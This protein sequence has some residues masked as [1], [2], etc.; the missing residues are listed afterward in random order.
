MVSS[1]HYLFI[2]LSASLLFAACSKHEEE[3]APVVTV[4]VAPVLSSEIQRTIRVQGL[5]YPL[6]QAAIVP[7]ITAPIKKVSVQ[8][9]DKVKAGQLLLELE[10]GDL[11]GAAHEAEAAYAAAEATYETTARAAVPEEAQ[12]AELDVQSAKTAMDAAQA[13]YDNRQQLFREGAIAQKDVNDA[14]VNFTQAKGQYE[15]AQKRLSDLRSFGHDQA[16]KNAA[17]QRDQAKARMDAALAQLSYSRITSP[18]DGVVTERPFYAGETPQ[19]GSPVVTVMDISQVIARTHISPTEAS[20]LKVGNEANIIG[21]DNTPISA[22]V[23][24]VSPALDGTNSTIEVWAQAD[25]PGDHLKPGASVRV[26]LI[27]KTVPNAL[28]IPQSALL[29]SGSGATSVVIVDAENKPHK[30]SVTT[31]VR[32]AGSVQITDGLES[33][34]R[35]VTTGAFELAKL[36]P[37]VLAKT[38]VQIAPPKEEEEEEPDSP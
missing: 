22:K 34:Q 32:D 10:N 16:L 30:K 19:S 23:T 26:E 20:E 4:D 15:M 13:V 7:K 31:G 11:A 17:A 37:D 2:A 8:K 27:A 21:P 3:E 24:Q 38:K 29:T 25:N 36:E 18:I 5:V 12:K 6:Q 14:Q 1:K 33:G 35:V 9:G 28:V